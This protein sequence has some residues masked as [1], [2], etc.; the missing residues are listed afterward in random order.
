MDSK[1][2]IV[3]I[4]NKAGP[5]KMSLLLNKIAKQ[6]NHTLFSW[7]SLLVVA[8]NIILLLLEFI[9][10]MD[11]TNSLQYILPYKEIT[12]NHKRNETQKGKESI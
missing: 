8:L 12:Y 11:H 2:P 6:T 7:L 1:C 3:C 10:M 4:S 9:L 5:K